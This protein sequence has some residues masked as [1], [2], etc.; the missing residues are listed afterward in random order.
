MALIQG[1]RALCF[2]NAL[3]R[4]TLVVDHFAFLTLAPAFEKIP[5]AKNPYHPMSAP[6]IFSLCSNQEF[7]QRWVAADR[8]RLRHMVMVP[9]L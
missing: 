7:F 8:A 1:S 6:K 4:W 5:S 2:V 3:F 9:S